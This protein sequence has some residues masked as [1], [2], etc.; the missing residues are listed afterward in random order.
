MRDL[1][2]ERGTSLRDIAELKRYWHELTWKSL[3]PLRY[4]KLGCTNK[5]LRAILAFMNIRSKLN[6]TAYMLILTNQG[7][8]LQLT[9]ADTWG[10]ALEEKKKAKFRILQGRHSKLGKW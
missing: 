1:G 3:S 8:A 4:I 9:I 5:I 7:K 6:W 2:E 10:I